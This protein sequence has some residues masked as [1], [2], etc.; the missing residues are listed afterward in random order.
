MFLPTGKDSPHFSW[1]FFHKL[2]VN[3]TFIHN[4]AFYERDRTNIS[5]TIIFLYNRC[6]IRI[7]ILL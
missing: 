6:G 4:I 1:I 5:L 7:K 2:T 3:V